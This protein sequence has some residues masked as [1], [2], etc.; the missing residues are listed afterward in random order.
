MTDSETPTPEAPAIPAPAEVS[1]PDTS[2][3]ALDTA[4]LEIYNRN[5]GS[6]EAPA[7]DADDAPAEEAPEPAESPDA[8]AFGDGEP[9][10]AIA[11]PDSWPGQLSEKWSSLPR[12]VQEYVAQ[13]EKEAHARI[14][15]LGSV[16]SRAEPLLN[17]VK[18]YRH[19]LPKGMADEA[20]VRNLFA[21][22]ALL[23][24]DLRSGL[25]AIARSYGQ[26]LDALV[27]HREAPEVAA[28]RHEVAAYRAQ[29]EQQ[30]SLRET[31]KVET[32]N[33][34]IDRWS[35][36][37]PHFDAV[38]TELVAI[39]REIDRAGKTHEQV[40][41]EAYERACWANPDVR[42]K[43]MAEESAKRDREERKSRHGEEAQKARRSNAGRTASFAPMRG[44]SLDLDSDEDMLALYRAVSEA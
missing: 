2:D 20:A 29:Q 32:V 10:A 34:V 8:K 40:L 30:Q 39:A 15:Q 41:D 18:E 19:T 5:M 27:A 42:A 36:D 22:Q 7:K 37:K 11:K 24:Q 16:A 35:T 23:N 14:S 26:S 12:D 31:E 25:E 13:R 43:I 4:L 6:D 33:Q 44:K 1:A 17:V 9:T 38:F 28:L 3:D 21:A